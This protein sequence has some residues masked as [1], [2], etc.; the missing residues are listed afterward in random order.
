MPAC[1][2][3][4]PIHRVPDPWRD[5]NYCSHHLPAWVGAEGDARPQGRGGEAARPS[6]G[7]LLPG[8]GPAEL[9][10]QSAPPG[11]SRGLGTGSRGSGACAR[12]REIPLHCCVC[13]HG[14]RGHA[15]W[16]RGC[17]ASSEPPA[18]MLPG[19]PR[20]KRSILLPSASRDAAAMQ[21]FPSVPSRGQVSAGF[22]Q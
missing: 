14:L 21:P 7:L 4:H 15:A 17:V 20:F 8:C 10:A 9:K 16:D 18:G 12:A 11:V 3:S 6:A 19:T 22:A 13:E 1:S 2:H 5:S